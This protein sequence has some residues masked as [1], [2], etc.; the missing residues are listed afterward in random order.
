MRPAKMAAPPIWRAAAPFEAGDVG[1]GALGVLGAED[2][3]LVSEVMPG[4]VATGAVPV[5]ATVLL[6]PGTGYGAG[7]DEF[8][9]G[10]DTGA[11]T[12]EVIDVLV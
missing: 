5:G 7:D 2:G 12:E 4:E 1:A 11:T 3:E 6:P 10:V 8:I 9:A